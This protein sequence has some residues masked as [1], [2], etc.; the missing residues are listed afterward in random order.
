[1]LLFLIKAAISG[2]IV[3]IVSTIAK[4]Y[5]GWGGLIASLPLV[6]VL[7][8]IWLY[9]ESRDPERVAALASGTFW[10]IIPSIP[11]F[12]I[13]PALLRSGFPFWI[14]LAVG[15][16]VTMILYWLMTLAAPRLG[17]TL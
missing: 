1:M 9:S 8:M 7:A 4:R 5:P 10:F 2:L 16:A 12:L 17:I 6:S 11:L 13:V 15:C 3:A 14:A